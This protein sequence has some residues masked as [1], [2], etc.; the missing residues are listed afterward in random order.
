MLRAFGLVF[1]FCRV[2]PLSFGSCS[3]LGLELMFFSVGCRV[4]WEV[5]M[6][7]FLVMV[8]VLVFFVVD[9]WVMFW[10]FSFGCGSRI[11]RLPFV[12]CLGVGLGFLQCDPSQFGSCSSVGLGVG[13]FLLFVGCVG[14]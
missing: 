6:S 1:D 4:R 14:R 2:M 5:I 8:E 3:S 13:F 7:C 12:A 11:Q 9:F 10:T